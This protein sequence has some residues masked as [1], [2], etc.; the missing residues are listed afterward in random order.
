MRAKD[1][2]R[3]LQRTVDE[4]AVLNEIGKALTSSLEISEVMHLILDKVSQLLKPRN[5]SVLLKDANTG[6]LVFKA[7]VGPGAEALQDLRIAPGEGIA[8]WVATNGKPLRVEDVRKD[9]RFSARFDEASSFQTRSILCVP[10][11]FKGNVLGVIELVNSAAEPFFTE[12]DLRIL[13]TVAEF[14]AIAI[15][16]AQNFLKVQ[17]LTI[18]DDHTGLYNS[19]HLRR[20]LDTEV[21]RAT[22]FGHPV[23]L[24]FFDLDHFKQVNDRWGHQ[25]G[26]RLLQDVGRMLLKT[27]RSTDVPVRYGGDEFVVLLPETSKDQALDAARRLREE[28]SR[29]KWLADEPFGPIALTASFGVATFPDDGT[30]PDE[31]L[32]GS[33]K[34]M[35]RA[36]ARSRDT[37]EGATASDARP[38]VQP[39]TRPPA[40]MEP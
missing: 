21:V 5:W 19:R 3:E 25:V 30:T 16:N 37:V 11:L 10:L 12:E 22:R 24:I 28:L 40:G 14:S 27:L 34:A 8:G 15:E 18:L 23:S 29:T 2:L 32:R 17:E 7:A 33:D 13:N 4:L 26:S 1:L 38:S 20:T 6:E 36:K 31:L 35:Y 9:P 39:A